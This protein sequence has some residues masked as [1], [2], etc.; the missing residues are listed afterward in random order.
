MVT[1]LL[2]DARFEAHETG[3][4][5]PESPGRI[6]AVARALSGAGWTDDLVSIPA[7]EAS[8]EELCL[9]HEPAYVELVRREIVDEGRRRL[10]TGDTEV[11]PDSY[12]AARVATGGVLS[13]VDAVMAGQVRNAFC[14]IRP[15]GHHATANRGMGFCLFNHVAV[16]ARYAQRKH[17]IGRVLIVD[18]DVHHGN[19]TQEIFYGDGSVFYFSTHQHPWYPGTGLAGETGI[20]AGKG[21]TLNCPLPAGTMMEAVR[22]AFRNRLLPAMENFRPELIVISAGFDARHG[23]PLGG[24]LLRDEDFGEL[25][26]ILLDL[27][28]K[29]AK[30]RLISVLEGGY[31]LAGLGQAVLA[32]VGALA[33]VG[34]VTSDTR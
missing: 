28:D 16:A 2:L 13:A 7:R 19:G 27:A 22:D 33:R 32:H 25:T 11:G 20:G 34:S 8:V 23:D 30:G 14:A 3:P 12:M 24:F 6:R 17:G 9:A 29:F 31:D 10:S 26:R 15:P 21:T 5:H 4:G 1:G 18:W